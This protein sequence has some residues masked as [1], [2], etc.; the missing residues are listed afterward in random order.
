MLTS[1]L[2]FISV[3]SSSS[4]KEMSQRNFEAVKVDFVMNYSQRE[5]VKESILEDRN[6]HDIHSGRNHLRIHSVRN[7]QCYLPRKC[8]RTRSSI[9]RRNCQSFTC[10]S[11]VKLLLLP[12]A[13][14]PGDLLIRY[15]M[16]STRKYPTIFPEKMMTT[17]YYHM[18]KLPSYPLLTMIDMRTIVHD[19][20]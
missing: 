3:H 2:T 9:L 15:L 7:C 5:I 10:Q 14:C 1:V 11:T 6:C 4:F 17:P 20:V 12:S 18:L 19:D 8:Q 16:F 13:I